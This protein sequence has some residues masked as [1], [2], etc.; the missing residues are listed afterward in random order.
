MVTRSP[1]PLT[2]L[3]GFLGSGKTTLLQNVLQNKDGVKVAVIVN[4]LASVNVD[5]QVI[6]KDIKVCCLPS[7]EG[8]GG[9]KRTF[10]FCAEHL[11]ANE[12]L[13]IEKCM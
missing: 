13:H 11:D 6:S 1:L 8:N 12:L 5:A 7:P 4:D 10:H 2:L 9:W 3:S